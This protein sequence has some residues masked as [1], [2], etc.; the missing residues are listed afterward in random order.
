MIAIPPRFKPML[1]L[2]IRK[3]VLPPACCRRAVDRGILCCQTSGVCIHSAEAFH[4]FQTVPV[5]IM[6]GHLGR[7][8]LL[9]LSPVRAVLHAVYTRPSGTTAYTPCGVN[10]SNMLMR[11]KADNTEDE[12]I[13]F[14]SYIIILLQLLISL[15]LHSCLT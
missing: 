1:P 13:H 15:V 12:N 7:F 9:K 11:K 6:A 14:L 3:P 2:I 8:I 10:K 5:N 4:V